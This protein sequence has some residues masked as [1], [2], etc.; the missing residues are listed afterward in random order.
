MKVV[1]YYRYSTDN[2][3]QVDNSEARQRDTVERV[4]YRRAKEGWQLVGS[5]TDKAVSGTDDKPELLKLRQ[6][7]EEGNL[8]VDVIAIDALSR[9]SRRSLM[10]IGSD[11]RWIKEAGIKLSIASRNNGEPFTVEEFSDDLSLMVD[12]YQNNQYVKKIS[13]EVTNGLRTKFENGNLG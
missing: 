9:L 5:Y 13:R 8:N 2:K 10:D 6:A 7:V 3:N 12:Q 4:V 1:A 11:I